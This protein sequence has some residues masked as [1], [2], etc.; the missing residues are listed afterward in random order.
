VPL[1]VCGRNSEIAAHRHLLLPIT[2][3]GPGP[4]YP[5]AE[6]ALFVPRDG[7][8]TAN[9]WSVDA[10]GLLDLL[11]WLHRSYPPVPLAVTENGAA[12]DDYAD[13][14]GR[15]H[16]GERVRFL[17]EH[18]RA[19]HQA[20]AQGV[21]LIG[22]FVWSLLDNFEWAE[23]YSKRFGLVY[24]DYPTQRR[25]LKDSAHWYRDVIQRGGLEAGQ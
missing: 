17:Q 14:E 10:G 5:T 12:F 1:G 13:P 11:L 23:G 18:F 7:P 24:V 22:Y 16:D 9:G 8:R 19:A 20:L 2:E 6:D 15:V 4:E 3:S 25:L 21:D